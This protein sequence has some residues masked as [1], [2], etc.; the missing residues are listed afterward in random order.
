MNDK[1]ISPISTGLRGRCP[2]CGEGPIFD[3]FL[4]LRPSCD[5]CG[6]DFAKADAGDGPAI[7]VIFIAGFLSVALA[8]IARYGW[9]WS[10]MAAFGVSVL[11][12][13]VTILALLRPLKSILI[14]LQ[15]A[16]KAAEGQLEK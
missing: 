10:L 14:A 3:G 9:E 16:N 12:S 13:L 6:L 8:F 15:F 2:R 4:G 1:K 5:V 11:F 7:F